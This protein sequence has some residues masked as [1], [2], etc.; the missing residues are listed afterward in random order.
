MEVENS[1]QNYNLV[2]SYKVLDLDLLVNPD[3][4]YVKNKVWSGMSALN[5]TIKEQCLQFFI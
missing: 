2:S 1:G 4:R 5:N 3:Y